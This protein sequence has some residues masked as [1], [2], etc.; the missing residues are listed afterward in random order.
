MQKISQ[1]LEELDS[2]FAKGDTEKIRLFLEKQISIF[3][4]NQE[5]DNLITIWGSLKRG[6]NTAIGCIAW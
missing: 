5:T 6:K 2:L 1:I 3:K 4:E